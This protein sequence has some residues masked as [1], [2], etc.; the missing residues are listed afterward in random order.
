MGSFLKGENVLC[1]CG[2]IGGSEFVPTIAPTRRRRRSF[3]H[4]L[5]GVVDDCVD[6]ELESLAPAVWVREIVKRIDSCI[7]DSRIG[8]R[9]IVDH[10]RQSRSDFRGSGFRR[11]PRL[12]REGRRVRESV[13]RSACALDRHERIVA[14]RRHLRIHL[15]G[16]RAAEHFTEALSR[17][18]RLQPPCSGR[19]QESVLFPVPPARLESLRFDDPVRSALALLDVKLKARACSPGDRLTC[20]HDCGSRELAQRGIV[21]LD[22]HLITHSLTPLRDEP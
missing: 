13:D 10:A 21:Q 17:I 12:H 18:H 2:E 4:R 11:R 8:D 7:R 6:R 15:V 1:V 20:A 16:G 22:L 19:L 9:P 5:T 3:G 14:S